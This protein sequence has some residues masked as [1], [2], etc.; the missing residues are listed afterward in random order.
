MTLSMK[1]VEAIDETIRKLV[2]DHEKIS[3]K[4]WQGQDIQNPMVEVRDIFVTMDMDETADSMANQ[5]KCHI[6]WAEDHFKERISGK[7]TNP[8]V[9]YRNWPFYRQELDDARFR[10]G[11]G[12]FSHTY[13][14]RFWP[15][16]KDGI[17]Y[18]M[19]DYNDVVE[20]LKNDNT[21]RQAFLSIWHPEDQSNND[22]RLP[23]TIGYWFS[24]RH[25]KLSITYLIRSCDA[26]RHFR[27][28]VYMAQR[29][30]LDMAYKIGVKELGTLSM[31]IG[32]FHCFTSDLYTLKKQTK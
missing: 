11:G 23:C 6:P 25:G 5:S 7:A 3:S 21:T 29:L 10:K 28:D 15:P 9:E 31:W 22:Q 20:R 30:A 2:Y 16:K 13:Q 32:S 4:R 14:E 8:G 17:R 1:T 26:A 12:K 18:K 19:G 27:N 24:V